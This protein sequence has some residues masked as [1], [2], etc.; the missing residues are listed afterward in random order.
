MASEASPV[1]WLHRFVVSGRALWAY[2][3]AV[4][5]LLLITALV[6]GPATSVPVVVITIL[7]VVAFAVGVAK[8]RPDLRNGWWLTAAGAAA[9]ALAAVVVTEKP[10]LTGTLGAQGWV[11]AS[12]AALAFGLLVAGL[13]VLGRLGGQTES[14]DMLDA[15]LLAL[16]VFRLL[17]ATVI[18][19]V[20]PVSSVGVVTAVIF[21]IGCLLVFAMLC[22]ILLSTRIPTPAVALLLL[23]VAAGVGAAAAVMASSLSAGTLETSAFTGPLWVV[24]SILLG[25]AG[26]HPSL[27]RTRQEPARHRNALSRPRLALFAAV[28]LAVPLA[29]L[30]QRQQG[31]LY[32]VLDWLVPTATSAVILLLLVARLALVAGVAERRADALAR[33]SE[34][35]AVAVE[36]Q[37]RLQRQLRYQA[38]HDPLTGLVNR[39][40][41]AERIEWA[42]TRPVGSRRHTLAIIDVDHFKNFNDALGH[43]VGD[44]LLV[45]VGHRI[46]EELP[47]SGMVARLGG[48][49]FG[50]VLEDLSS[51]ESVDWAE[52][53]RQRLRHPFPIAGRELLVSV[54][55]GLLCTDP[56]GPQVP[57]SDAMRDADLALHAAKAA[58]GNRV[59]LFQPEL[60]NQRLDFSRI[61]TQLRQAVAAQE[62]ELHYQPVVELATERIVSV[63]ALLRWHPPG[64]S[65]VPPSTFI[66]VAEE[67]NLIGQL[68]AW[69]IRRACREAWPWYRRHGVGV[70]VNVSARQLDDPRFAEMVLAALR[71]TGLPS[72]AL[73]LEITESSLVATSTTSR[74]MDQLN[75]VRSHGVRVAIDDFGIGYSSLAYVGWLPVDTVKIDSSFVRNAPRPGADA[76]D[77]AFTRAILHLVEAMHLPAV[78]EGVEHP[79]QA[80]ALRALRCPYAQGYLFGRPM[81]PS[82][83]EK[84]LDRTLTRA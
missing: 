16:A 27:Q 62:L 63:E 71:D 80:T 50:V 44:E 46:L 60:R 68:G 78:A 84:L 36:E 41:L 56:H 42:L 65:P 24:C 57:P 26:L 22:R 14:A 3:A 40:V 73:T 10:I 58:G 51:D 72:D 69:V 25:A 64:Q 13:A 17:Y 47:P 11:T 31:P 23:A 53:V 81:P 39:I 29:W 75:E 19:P 76:E 21:P 32:E 43:A 7:G 66:P 38:M 30:F 55:I 5:V 4:A 8:Q 52:R 82:A 48:D 54:S 12:L 70:S 18:H 79:E 83:L 37:R 77:W 20:A 1:G 15:T 45:A 59:T 61:S 74:A 34:D 35:L 67:T 33:R 6:P 9:G 2:L 28:A 49:E